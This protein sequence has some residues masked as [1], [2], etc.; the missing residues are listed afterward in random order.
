[1]RFYGYFTKVPR[2]ENLKEK[3]PTTNAGFVEFILAK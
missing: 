2:Y 1:M 3:I